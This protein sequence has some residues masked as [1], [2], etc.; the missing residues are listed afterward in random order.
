[1]NCMIFCTAI[2]NLDH[3]PNQDRAT[4][5]SILSLWVI[6]FVVGQFIARS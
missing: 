6:L 5:A 4:I 2:E 1:M 3:T